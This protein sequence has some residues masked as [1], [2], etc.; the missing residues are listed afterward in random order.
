MQLLDYSRNTAVNF[1]DPY[2][3]YV[4]GF[5]IGSPENIRRFPEDK[6]P[7]YNTDM[8]RYSVLGV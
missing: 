8:G 2:R 5:G 7:H 3:L 4:V 1:T 6:I